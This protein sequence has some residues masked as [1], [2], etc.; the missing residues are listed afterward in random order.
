MWCKQTRGLGPQYIGL[1]SIVMSV[2]D[3][4]E[5]QQTDGAAD[6]VPTGLLKDLNVVID[7]LG[8]IENNLRQ[9]Q[10][11]AQ[12]AKEASLNYYLE[13]AT[14]IAEQRLKE[15]KIQKNWLAGD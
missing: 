13:M 15:A 12:G 4:R 11:L 2:E 3:N 8:F 6:A 14:Q 1:G 5:N 10:E 7:N 9:L